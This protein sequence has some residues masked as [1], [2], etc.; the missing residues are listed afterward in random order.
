MNT[1]TPEIQAGLS[2]ED[3]VRLDE[4][5]A[6]LHEINL[7]VIKA[8]GGTAATPDAHELLERTIEKNHAISDL[9]AKLYEMRRG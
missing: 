5:L 4:A 1:T 2:W 6:T 3:V 7:R 8:L 9:R